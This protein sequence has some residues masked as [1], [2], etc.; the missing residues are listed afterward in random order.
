MAFTVH[1]AIHNRSGRLITLGNIFGCIVVG[2]AEFCQNGEAAAAVGSGVAE[3]FQTFLGADIG[4]KLQ[5][6]GSGQGVQTGVQTGLVGKPKDFQLVFGHGNAVGGHVC[7]IPNG[8]AFVAGGISIMIIH[9]L[10]GGSALDSAADRAGL[11]RTAGGIQPFV[12]R[13]HTTGNAADGANACGGAGGVD[14]AMAGGFF[15]KTADAAGSGFQTSVIVPAV[16]G[17]TGHD[18]VGDLSDLGIGENTAPMDGAVVVAFGNHDMVGI[19]FQNNDAVGVVIDSKDI[20][21]PN[22][23]DGDIFTDETAGLIAECGVT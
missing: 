7:L 9:V 4:G 11:G 15:L 13:G 23:I 12:A 20:A 5:R 21:N 10:T 1:P 22:V 6:L 8:A 2:K 3:I 17:V 19:D 18:V 16:F 14:P